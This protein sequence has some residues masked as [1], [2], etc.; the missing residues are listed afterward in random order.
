MAKILVTGGLG[1]IGN[2]LVSALLQRG[3]DDI[4]VF[5]I[6]TPDK[7]LAY[8]IRDVEFIRG[9]LRDTTVLE[10]A[11]EG[12]DT[13]VHLAAH[14][15]VMDSLENPQLNFE[16]NAT[17]TFNLL[18]LMR[19]M[20]IGYIV[21]ASTGGAILGN[22]TPPVHE[23]MPARPLSPYGASKLA[24][25]G[26]CSAFMGAYGIKTVSLR[27]SNIYG[28]YS[29]YKGSVV[30]LF[31]RQIMNGE[32]LKIYGDGNQ[33]RDFLFAED[34]ATGI[35]QVIEQQATGVY[36]LGTGIGT[37]V[38][39]V[40]SILKDVASKKHAVEVEYLP[41]R[42]AEVLRNVCDISRAKAS[43]AYAPPTPVDTGIVKTWEWF[44][45]NARQVE[46]A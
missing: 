19:K 23:D 39:K 44:Q 27:F 5:D 8:S 37:S 46:A 13:V 25:E 4:R 33:T 31:I 21:N 9:D 35:L 30:P 22:A 16:T 18:C 7:A 17:G 28:H 20:E 42:D 6:D 2:N 38:N 1:F 26:Y 36:Q 14:T 41:A 24:A 3:K 45:S 11:L 29:G 32:K 40:L 10:T 43:F 34:L 12:V 15:R